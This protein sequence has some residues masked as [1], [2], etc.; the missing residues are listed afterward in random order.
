MLYVN[1]PRPTKL[2]DPIRAE[3]SSLR[4]E[5]EAEIP[6]ISRYLHLQEDE[7]LQQSIGL[8]RSTQAWAMKIGGQ[9]ESL[10]EFFGSV[11]EHVFSI[12]KLDGQRG[13]GT[14]HL[15]HAG[16]DVLVRVAQSGKV[17]IG[18]HATQSVARGEGIISWV[19]LRQRALLIKDLR[20]SDF[21]SIYFNPQGERIES[22]ST[23]TVPLI[24]E[25]DLVGVLSLES[26]DPGKFTESH[27]RTILFAASSAGLAA[28]LYM[29]MAASLKAANMN[30]ELLKRFCAPLGSPHAKQEA[31]DELARIACDSLD[32]RRCDIW[33]LDSVRRQFNKLGATHSLVNGSLPRGNGW[34]AYMCRTQQAV[35]MRHTG[36]A[37]GPEVSYWNSVLRIWGSTPDSLAVPDSVNPEDQKEEFKY[38][39]G[40]PIIDGQVSIGVA[41]VKYKDER[42]RPT[43]EQ[44][45]LAERLAESV[46]RVLKYRE[47]LNYSEEPDSPSPSPIPATSAAEQEEPVGAEVALH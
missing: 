46:G 26:V 30:S 39:L 43:H 13:F 8:L 18:L 37:T 7:A 21:E 3:I 15:Y 23:L 28:R 34:S 19:A 44:M 36:R 45:R 47:L 41:W 31:L 27:V 12:V 42:P 29:R 25:K 10:D 9:R 1:F 38:Q 20:I 22:A 11:L 2:T 17:P 5:L 24:V 33:G 6:A 32:A 16:D 4:K 35:W 14:V 40:I